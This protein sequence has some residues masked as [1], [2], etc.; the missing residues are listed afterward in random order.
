MAT[1][2]KLYIEF[3]NLDYESTLYGPAEP[4]Q[5]LTRRLRPEPTALEG[6]FAAD[7]ANRESAA[8]GSRVPRLHGDHRLQRRFLLAQLADRPERPYTM[9][10]GA[11][12]SLVCHHTLPL[13]LAM[14]AA[15]EIRGFDRKWQ[16]HQP[17]T[18]KAPPFSICGR[19][20]GCSAEAWM[21]RSGHHTNHPS[22]GAYG[23][24]FRGG[25]R[26]CRW[27]AILSGG[28]ISVLHST[29]F[30]IEQIE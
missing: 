11:G 26:S 21:R 22:A 7:A 13:E 10:T 2:K 30:M 16:S 20:E 3:K 29:S 19:C 24:A 28:A 9:D 12:G 17:R 1:G 15:K 25:R 23:A 8:P 5:R 14:R 6:P 4:V 27:L 18:D